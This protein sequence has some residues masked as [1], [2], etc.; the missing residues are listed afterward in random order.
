MGSDVRHSRAQ[1]LSS[2]CASWGGS[3]SHPALLDR[4]SQYLLWGERILLLQC[5]YTCVGANWDKNQTW[6]ESTPAEPKAQ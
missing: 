5:A 6:H 4:T 3:P 1:N 2:N